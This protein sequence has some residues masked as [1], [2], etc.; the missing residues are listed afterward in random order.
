M[1]TWGF[2]TRMEGRCAGEQSYSIWMDEADHARAEAVGVEGADG[3]EW[4]RSIY[5]I[6][7]SGERVRD[8][9]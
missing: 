6:E 2:S 9:Y 1:A 8:G 4:R 3:Y 5:V 7:M